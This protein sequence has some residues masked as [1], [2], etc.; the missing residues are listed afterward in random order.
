M[1]EGGNMK[2]ILFLFLFFVLLN[3][4]Y[5]QEYITYSSWQEEYPY[6]LDTIFIESEERYLWY[7]EII[8]EET[9]E[10]EREETSEYYKELDG[11]IKIEESIKTFY[12]YITNKLV[13]FDSHGNI[14][15]DD[16]YC[17]NTFANHSKFPR[18]YQV[19]PQRFD[20][21]TFLYLVVKSP[22]CSEWDIWNSF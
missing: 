21:Q 17:Q 16:T 12:R 2:K 20:L 3:N 18:T 1:I 7:R 4:L 13:L 11:Y 15:Y 6:W 19:F 14:V 8:N 10:L 5:A 22:I 9:G